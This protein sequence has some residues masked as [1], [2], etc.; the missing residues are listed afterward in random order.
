LNQLRWVRALLWLRTLPERLTGKGETPAITATLEDIT[1]EG[2]GFV[3]LNEIPGRE[4][5]VG[6]IGKFRQ[7][8]IE[9]LRLGPEEIAAFGEPG[10]GKLLWSIA[11]QPEGPARS[12]VSAE[13]RVTATDAAAWKRFRRY[14][15]QGGRPYPD[16]RA[17]P[18][19]SNTDLALRLRHPF[20]VEIAVLPE[21]HE[22]TVVL[23][24]FLALAP[25]LVKLP[26]KVKASHIGYRVAYV[27]GGALDDALE[28]LS[29][30]FLV[31]RAR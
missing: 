2:T 21:V 7:P 25:L 1:R 24:S 29:R 20:A 8:H 3:L 19:A 4:F 30:L 12:T 17:P 23:A 16:R 14:W 5:T 15:R 13:L 6:S 22:P 18:S 26:E 27:L 11:V 31:S 10:Y 28:I 9:F